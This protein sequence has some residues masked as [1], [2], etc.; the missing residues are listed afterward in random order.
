MIFYHRNHRQVES[1]GSLYKIT[2]LYFKTVPT[3]LCPIYSACTLNP[4]DLYICSIV[5]HP[6]CS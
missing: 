5:R 2:M 4:P 1:L 3:Q 6:K